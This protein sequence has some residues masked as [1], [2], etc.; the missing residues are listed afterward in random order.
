MNLLV[1]YA[2]FR[3]GILKLK[4]RWHQLEE[5]LPRSK[6]WSREYNCLFARHKSKTRNTNRGCSRHERRLH[7]K[8]L[9][10]FKAQIDESCGMPWD[11]ANVGKRKSG[12]DLF[13]TIV[14]SNCRQVPFKVF[15]ELES[16]N[17]IILDEWS[18]Y[19]YKWTV[20]QMRATLPLL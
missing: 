9:I 5:I 17:P 8:K 18:R 12:T 7:E 15:G 14:G 1:C 16:P 11:H 10:M 2:N 4:V 20:F 19:L 3:F 6:H 13:K